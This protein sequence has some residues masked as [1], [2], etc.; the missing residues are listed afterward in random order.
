MKVKLARFCS[1]QRVCFVLLGLIGV[2]LPHAAFAAAA[3]TT[4]SRLMVADFNQPGWRSNLGGAYGIWSKD[5]G[6]ATQSCIGRLVEDPRVGPAGFS[7]MMEYDVDSPNPAYNGFWMKLPDIPLKEYRYLTLA[8]R[9][10]AD[11]E[12]T[13]RVKLELK[14][15]RRSASFQLTGIKSDWVRMR[16]A[17]DQ[18][19]GIQNIKAA[20]E[21]VI[22]FS[23]DV[24]DKKVGAVYLDEVAFEKAP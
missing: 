8:L 11:R 3:E 16:I 7:L 10:D 21:F 23:D 13:T 18:F 5:P 2:G 19:S 4:G 6:D 20:N 15:R 9:G 24:A 14:G 22:V 12:F 17:L 1:N